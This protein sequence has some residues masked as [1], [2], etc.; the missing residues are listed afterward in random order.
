V[1]EMRKGEE[2]KVGKEK[3]GFEEGKVGQ[4]E[5]PKK[6]GRRKNYK[7]AQGA[8]DLCEYKLMKRKITGDERG[9]EWL[10]GKSSMPLG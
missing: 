5:V 7:S 9:R 4:R 2:R 3:T 8:Y 1:F 6:E 10:G